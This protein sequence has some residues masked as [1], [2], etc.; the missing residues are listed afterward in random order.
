MLYLKQCVWERYEAQSKSDSRV[1]PMR[2]GQQSVD[3]TFGTT[4]FG[5]GYMK[6][7]KMHVYDMVYTME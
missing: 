7:P 4:V 2:Y 3:T 5:V 6:L 1:G